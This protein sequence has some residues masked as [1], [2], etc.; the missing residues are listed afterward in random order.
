MNNLDKSRATSFPR[1]KPGVNFFNT[2][3]LDAS[4]YVGFGHRG[5]EIHSQLTPGLLALLDGKRTLNSII[6]LISENIQ[7]PAGDNLSFEVTEILDALLDANLLEYRS[8]QFK[9]FK[10][11][12]YAPVNLVSLNNRIRAE[13]NLYSW[14][15]SVGIKNSALD[16]ISKR[17]GFSIILFGA[18]R[19]ALSLFSILKASGFSQIKIIDR[20]LAQSKRSKVQ[21]APD[22]VCGL[23]IRGADVGL[24]KEDVLADIARNSQLFSPTDLTFP[25]RPD[26]IIATQKV[27]QDSM[28]RW[29]S[30]EISHLLIGDL[31]EEKIVIGPIVLPGKSPCLN[32]INLYRAEQLPYFGRLELLAGFSNFNLE[33]PSAQVALIAGLVATQVIEFCEVQSGSRL[34]AASELAGITQSINLLDPLNLCGEKR[35]WQPHSSCGC[36]SLN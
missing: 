33:L 14:H 18:N 7:L 11:E 13:E 3:S 1:F 35:Y 10:N 23:A 30:E 28:Q 5:I 21:I 34:E 16:L 25:E 8:T 36:H 12:E 29:M 19:L 20:N 17:A 32:C 24:R 15:R 31:I 26:F 4:C 27:A 22:Q 2:Q 6:E 9:D